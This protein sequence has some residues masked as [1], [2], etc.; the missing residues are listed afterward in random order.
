[1]AGDEVSCRFCGTRLATMNCPRCFG[2]TFVGSQFCPHCGGRTAPGAGEKTGLKCPR[3]AIELERLPVG[4]DEVEQ[5]GKCGGIWVEG[6]TF[7]RICTDVEKQAAA[8]LIEQPG[9]AQVDTEVK[10]LQCP[11]CCHLM[12]RVNYARR[13]RVIVDV[14]KPHGVWLDR[15]EM[16]RIVEFVRGGGM[17]RARALE[18][19]E[20]E[21]KQAHLES[22][23]RL[24]GARIEEPISR[25]DWVVEVLGALGRW[26]GK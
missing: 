18:K 5:C 23:Q 10:Y 19:A 25:V 3:C 11:K 9:A 20:I 14:C 22:M 7:S 6:G 4:A 13:S 21:R 24:D 16:R 17:D 1:M 12:N 15:D 26:L 8:L 2:L